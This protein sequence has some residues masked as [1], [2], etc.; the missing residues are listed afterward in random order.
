MNLLWT[1]LLAG[2]IVMFLFNEPNLVLSTATASIYDSLKLCFSLAGIYIF[3]LGIIKII[4]DCGLAEKL[5][6][7]LTPIIYVLFGNIS[8]EASEL[9]AVNMSANI[10]GLGNASLPAGLKAMDKLNNKQNKLSQQ[11][12]MLF[13]INCCSIQLLPS[14]VILMRSENGSHASSDIILPIIIVSLI[15]FFVTIFLVKLLFKEK[16]K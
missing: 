1:I 10:L 4:Q 8:K 14:T 15:C 7:L 6:K 12:V 11:M 3:W 16:K 2:S 13:A 9:I 5:S